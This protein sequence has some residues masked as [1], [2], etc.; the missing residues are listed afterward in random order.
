M[1]IVK[2]CIKFFICLFTIVGAI[3][4]FYSL[5]LF[6]GYVDG[7]AL[8]RDPRSV[9]IRIIPYNTKYDAYRLQGRY[10]D[11]VDNSGMTVFENQDDGSKVR[12]KNATIIVEHPPK[13]RF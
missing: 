10:I 1:I 13:E 11:F 4:A 5:L 12:V 2:D 6:L 8:A 9:S 7:Q 3:A